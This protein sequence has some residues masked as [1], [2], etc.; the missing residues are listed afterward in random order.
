MPGNHNPHDTFFRAVFGC[1]EHAIAHF[2]AF[3]PP[4]VQSTLDLSTADLC[5][6]SFVDE[7][8]R[9]RHT[10]LLYRVRAAEAEVL[11][12]LLFE[13]QS[14]CDPLMP[15]RLMVYIVRIWEA[16]RSDHPDATEVPAVLPLVLY[17]GQAAWTAPPDLL[18]VLALPPDA[19]SALGRHL[20]R[21]EYLL[22]DLSRFRD[23]E[24]RRGALGGLALL[25][26]KH[27]RDDDLVDRL[28]AWADLFARVWRSPGGLRV[29][30]WVI[31]YIMDANPVATFPLIDAK[32]GSA[33][34]QEGH[35]MTMSA[36]Q[37]LRQES[38]A[39][40]RVE[41]RAEKARSILLR[42]LQLKF[43][44]LS[45]DVVERV[46]AA[47]EPELDRWSDRVLTATT[48]DEVFE[49]SR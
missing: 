1:S 5:P 33:L 30:E 13:H 24:L 40:G 43:G 8:L 38:H 48:L 3:L 10:D 27:I 18:G 49:T 34:G 23:E 31:R 44:A 29:I 22:L 11:V 32:L 37:K 19:R 47:E 12:Y 26:L 15:Y 46:G 20:P 28:P 36:Y 39:E 41:G 25:L 2:R 35:E 4:S 42:Q 9:D 6:G 45:A 21:L 16:W 14:T 7:A 17:H